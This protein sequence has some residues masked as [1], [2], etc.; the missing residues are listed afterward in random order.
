MRY[1]SIN[2]KPNEFNTLLSNFADYASG[3]EKYKSYEK[4]PYSTWSELKYKFKGKC[5]YIDFDNY[6][7]EVTIST[8]DGEEM[9]FNDKDKSLGSFLYDEYAWQIETSY[10]EWKS[11]DN[12]SATVKMVNGQALTLS[13]NGAW[14]NA[15]SVDGNATYY[16]VDGTAYHSINDEFVALKADVDKLKNDKKKEEENTMKGFNFDF[17]PCTNDNVKMSMYGL[18]VQNNAGV[19]VSYNAKSGELIDV[20]ILNFDGRKFMFKMPVAIKDI[21][22]GDIVVHNRIPMFVIGVDNG[23]VAVDPRAGEEK[24]II[25]TT[26][27]FGFNFVTKVVSMFNAVGQ[28]PTPDA[29]FGNM[30]P[31]M[32]MSEDNKDIDPMML[33]LMMNQNGGASTGFDMSNPMM[34]YFLMGKDS[35]SNSDVLP[36]LMMMN[37]NQQPKHVCNCGNHQE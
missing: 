35:K 23:I 17:G 24:K 6:D 12:T 32:L 25:P 14:K 7:G 11:E 1:T 9:I 4:M 20:D 10:D 18:A 19:W 8:N 28:A 27:M 21:K 29:P 34:L 2:L 16:S 13:S 26:N 3:K 15:V 31:F 37:M 33:M 36:M 30:L 22:V 5:V